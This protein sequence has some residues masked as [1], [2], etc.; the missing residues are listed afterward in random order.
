MSAVVTG[1]GV[2]APTGIGTE[3]SWSAMLAGRSGIDTIRSFDAS[4]YQTRLAGQVP[5]FT[6]TDHMSSR[7]VAQTDR[8]TQLALYATEAGLADAGVLPLADSGF[9][10]YEMAVVT[11]SASAGNAFGQRELGELWSKGPG[12]VS[13]YQSIAWFYAATTGQISIRHGMRGPCGVISGEQAGG[14]DAVGQARRVLRD[15][16]RLVVT[17][18]TEAAVSPYAM[19]CQQSTGM[20]SRVARP[21]GAYRP[22]D[23]AAAGYVP[24]EGG[25]I[26]I[27]E[28]GGSA[29]ARGA[30]VYGEV[31]GYAA[32]FD[33]RPG[34]GG[35]PGLQRAAE[36]ALA[37]AGREPGDVDV[38][39]AD[40][41]GVPDL[42]RA[43]AVALTR[44]FGARGVA[45]TAPKTM[46]GRLLA[47]GAS[48]DLATALLA[49]RDGVIP[50]TVHVRP[51]P[52]AELDLVVDAPRPATIRTALVLARGAGGF[53]S[54]IVLTAA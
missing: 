54:A 32:T 27:V 46:T 26:L 38:V 51:D 39:F 17:G 15:G 36:L 9:G 29:A 12:W 2:V 19:V 14:L 21:D 40:A 6:A 3:A 25:A 11:A 43:E 34:S 18:G 49:I 16:V 8:W 50:P 53:N 42:D 20:L 7:L 30:R 41:M 48:L 10:E 13:A 1:I 24:G 44:L 5:G 22:F 47:G 33:P 35:E 52:A 23:R 45:V 28:D 37:D 31:A 4:G